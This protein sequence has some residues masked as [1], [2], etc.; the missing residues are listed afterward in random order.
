VF[1]TLWPHCDQN[2]PV[3]AA[4]E[5]SGDGLPR[6]INRH[7][8]KQRACHSTGRRVTPQ[9]HKITDPTGLR[10]VRRNQRPAM[11][12]DGVSRVFGYFKQHSPESVRTPGLF[13]QS[14]D[15]F[16]SARP[17]PT[18]GNSLLTRP[19]RWGT[20][21]MG[22]RVG[23]FP[24]CDDES[25]R[26]TNVSLLANTVDTQTT[27]PSTELLPHIR[28]RERRSPTGWEALRWTGGTVPVNRFQMQVHALQFRSRNASPGLSFQGS[29]LPARCRTAFAT[30]GFASVPNIDR[31]YL[32][33]NESYRNHNS[34][35][36]GSMS[37]LSA[38][39]RVGVHVGTAANAVVGGWSI[40]SATT[41]SSA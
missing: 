1:G 13:L 29:Y 14:A 40:N 26:A 20:P 2:L 8:S 38:R 37:C 31:R 18:V 34:S 27:K 30:V 12:R 11:I 36:S 35:C 5:Y 17:H 4:Q 10:P 41:F 23:Y 39:G 3:L 7:S 28:T 33:P 21:L 9:L 32:W 16:R 24:G 19:R 22:G 25:S 6:D 15:A